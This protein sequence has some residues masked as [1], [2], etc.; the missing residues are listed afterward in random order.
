VHR[1]HIVRTV[2]FIAI[3]LATAAG[4]TK[5]TTTETGGASS[6][7]STAPGTGANA[8]PGATAPNRSGTTSPAG[9]KCGPV[10]SEDSTT[11]PLPPICGSEGGATTHPTAPPTTCVSAPATTGVGTKGGGELICSSPGDDGSVSSPPMT[12]TVPGRERPIAQPDATHGAL[13]IV[14]GGSPCPKSADT[15]VAMFQ[16]VPAKVHLEQVGGSATADGETAGMEGLLSLQLD[17]GTWRITAIPIAGDRA[18][19]AQDVT[20]TAG[21]ATSV[22]VD[23]ALPG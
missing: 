1:R 14:T 4:C 17:P 15:C 8:M 9:P 11:V 3:V 23:C 10:Y 18:C 22:S 6:L 2:L 20:I 7:G 21:E 12:D 19:S 13:S 5:T 16:I